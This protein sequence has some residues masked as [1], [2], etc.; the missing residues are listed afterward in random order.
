M[1]V[2]SI[3]V[4]N[5]LENPN[6]VRNS[7]LSSNF[8]SS[9]NYPGMR[10]G[11]SDADYSNYVKEKIEKIINQAIEWDSE[12]STKF[13]ICFETDKTWIHWDPAEW[14]GILYLTPNS[15]ADSGT[16]IYQYKKTKEFTYTN[17][18]C[19]I[20]NNPD[21]WEVISYIGNVYNRLALFK[22]HTYHR[23]SRP[24]FGH[25]KYS[26]RLTQTF[27]FKTMDKEQL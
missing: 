16:A 27:F 3:I 1:N 18:D 24:G 21:S 7:A 5:F 25:D 11:I 26:A 12:D 2:L 9:G 20:D 23:S 6:D 15:P 19:T 4:D 22:G 10:S 8:T 14:T 13:Q 17:I